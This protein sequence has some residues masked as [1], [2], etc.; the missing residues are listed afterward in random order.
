[1]SKVSW[2]DI[3]AGLQS[4]VF[5]SKSTFMKK[6]CTAYNHYDEKLDKFYVSFI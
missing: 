5:A 3:F 2:K 6:N 4:T 1:M